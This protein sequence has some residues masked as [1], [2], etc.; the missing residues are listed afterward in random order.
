MSWL[1]FQVPYLQ[2]SPSTHTLMAA[3]SRESLRLE[4]ILVGNIFYGS[5]SEDELRVLAARAC[6][7]LGGIRHAAYNKSSMLLLGNDCFIE[8]VGYEDNATINTAVIGIERANTVNAWIEKNLPPTRPSVDTIYAIAQSQDGMYLSKVGSIGLP[9]ARQ[10]YLPET[11]RELDHVIRDLLTSVPC[12]RLSILSGV[13]GTGKTFL[14][15]ALVNGTNAGATFVIIPPH[16]IHSLGDPHLVN[17]LIEH[18][19]K[20]KTKPMVLVLEDADSALVPRGTDNM[21]SISGLLNLSD[22]LLGRALDIRVIATTNAEIREMDEALTRPGRLCRH[23]VTAPL[24]RAQAQTLYNTLAS[25]KEHTFTG[26]ATLAEIYQA[27][28]S[29]V[30]ET[31]APKS[32]SIGF[33]G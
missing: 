20:F 24:S 11:L 23:I 33:G 28:N 3:L 12:G 19:E 7:E 14:V 25:G 21:H 30:G 8:L 22:G 17:L 4:Q 18:K 13:P 26:P 6:K 10:N 16:M 15:R 29:D 31:P 2:G 32:K 1:E 9:L 27:A 5:S